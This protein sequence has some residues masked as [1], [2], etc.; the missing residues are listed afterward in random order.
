MIKTRTGFA[1]TARFTLL[2]GAAALALPG[3]AHAQDA[4]A[5]A[6]AQEQVDA[7]GDNFPAAE[8]TSTGNVI[9]VTA[10]KREQTLQETPV[11]V[12]VTTG[13]T[14]ERAQI[15]DV[16]DLQTVNPSLRVS[17]LQNSSSST[18]IIRGFGNG[19]NNFGIEPSVGVFIDGVFRSRSASSLNDLASRCS[20]GRSRPCSE[21]TP[22]PASSRSLPA[23]RS[24]NSAARSRRLTATTIR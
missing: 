8:D 12:T 14:L 19:D 15:R 1:G 7:D 22:A 17:Q 13:E 9:V 16:L 23:S 5:Q 4:A 21:R 18:F 24:S 20:T 10:T 3:V 11:S 6:E 2:A